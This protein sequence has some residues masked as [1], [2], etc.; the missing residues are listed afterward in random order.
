MCLI[1]TLTIM[2]RDWIYAEPVGLYVIAELD[3]KIVHSIEM[4][5][6][7]PDF[8]PAG[9]AFARELERYFRTGKDNFSAYSPD[10]SGMTPFRKKVMEELRKVQAGET[11]SY[12]E[13]A[14]AAGSPGAARAVGNV[15][16]TNPVPLF[17]PC[18][19]VIATNGLGGFTG[20]LDVKRALLKLESAKVLPF[21]N[22]HAGCE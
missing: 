3:G 20:G 17:V 10:Y 4:T 6:R 12:G 1:I 5:G 11:I 8:K 21:A 16:A 13:L 18:H 15:M 19:R 14:A 9:T 7:K 22:S 2:T